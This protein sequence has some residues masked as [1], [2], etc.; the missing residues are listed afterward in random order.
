MDIKNVFNNNGFIVIKNLIK[1]KYISQLI[2]SL[3]IFKKRNSYYF[4]QNNHNW[5][6]SG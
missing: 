4:T 1:E 2:N 5:V 3:E 6:K